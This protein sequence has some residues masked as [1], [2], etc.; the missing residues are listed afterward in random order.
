[1][2]KVLFI[3]DEINTWVGKTFAWLILILTL[4]I[5]YAVIARY[6]F[7]AP[8]DWSADWGII[9]YGTFIMM[10]GP[11]TLAR[12]A[13]VRGDMFYRNFSP[14]VQGIMDLTLYFIFFLPGVIA[15]VYSGYSFALDAWEVQEKSN[16]TTLG[17]PIYPF[18]TVIPIA[19]AL[20]LLQGLAEIV[21][22][23]QAIQ[24]NEWPERLHD[25]EETETKLAKETQV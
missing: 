14:R 18:K 13:H 5:G 23:I 16:L 2:K 15:L 21:R 12:N 22:C 1:L 4:I 7:R 24:K 20:L 11:Y 8:T 19:G 9:L 10:G 25:V 17:T 6:I 3:I